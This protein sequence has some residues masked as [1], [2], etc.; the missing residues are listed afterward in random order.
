MD[1]HEITHNRC[2]VGLA[3]ALVSELVLVLVLVLLS[4]V[5]IGGRWSQEETNCLKIPIS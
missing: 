3:S 5:G 1:W 4:G 2:S